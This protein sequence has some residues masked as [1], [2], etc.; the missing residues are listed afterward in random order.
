MNRTTAAVGSTLFFALAPGGAAVLAP[1]LLTGWHTGTALPWPLRALGAVLILAGLA[2]IVPAFVRFVMEGRGTPAP[3]AAPTTLVIGGLYR[4]VRNPMYLSVTSA[5]LGQALL[6]GR[7][8]LV[9]YAAVF[10]LIA[11]AFVKVYEE[12]HLTRVFGPAYERYRRDV[13][14]WWPRL[15]V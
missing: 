3:I 14:G 12:P 6:L 4:Y 13:P 2:V 1:W 10:I 5:I 15:R 8:V 7:W 11:Y 9:G